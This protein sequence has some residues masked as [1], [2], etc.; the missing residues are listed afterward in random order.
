[1]A[2]Q[3]GRLLALQGTA[4][5]SHVQ[6]RLRE[7]YGERETVSRRAR[8]ALRSFVDWGVLCET[9]ATGVYSCG[10]KSS[11]D[12]AA[13]VTWLVEAALHSQVTHTAI[14]SDLITSP[15]FFP[16]NFQGINLEEIVSASSRL[17]IIR[18][19]LNEKFVQIR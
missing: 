4:S 9:G 17:E 7:Q 10:T 8:Y 16:F 2:T 11:I 19:G 5:A 15:K 13:L 12:D 3:V 1:M 6:R 18:H 14:L